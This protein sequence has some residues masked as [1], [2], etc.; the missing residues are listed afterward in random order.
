MFHVPSPH[1]PPGIGVSVAMGVGVWV[2][3]GPLGVVVGVGVRVRV[4]VG[5][6]PPVGVG[7]GPPPPPPPH[8]EGYALWS[9]RD[10]ASAQSTLNSVTQSTHFTRS[11][12]VFT[13]AAQPGPPFGTVTSGH[14]PANPICDGS[15]VCET[16]VTPSTEPP[17]HAPQIFAT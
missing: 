5:P 8:S 13:G 7:V 2:C 10:S 16:Q 9:G 6:P 12:S 11:L 15:Y 14:V 3:A 17:P 4:A 1:E